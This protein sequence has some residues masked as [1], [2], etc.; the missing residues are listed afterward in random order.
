MVWD[1]ITSFTLT[2]SPSDSHLLLRSFCSCFWS[3][4]KDFCYH[5]SENKSWKE[6]YKTTATNSPPWHNSYRWF[7]FSVELI[8]RACYT[9]ILKIASTQVNCK[10]N[11]IAMGATVAFLF[12][13][14][15]QS[16]TQRLS[17][18]N[19]VKLHL[20]VVSNQILFCFSAKPNGL[21]EKQ[22]YL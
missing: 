6:P 16:I 5:W 8:D 3:K 21:F 19:K 1:F 7:H 18:Q 2:F 9:I 11:S 4:S 13:K 22:N 10:L 15:Q 20:V 14:L 17:F 12:I